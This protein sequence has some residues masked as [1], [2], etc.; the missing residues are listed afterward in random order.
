MSEKLYLAKQAS[1]SAVKEYKRLMKEALE[2]ALR[3]HGLSGKK[4][5]ITKQKWLALASHKNVYARHKGAVI[6]SSLEKYTGYLT[7]STDG[8]TASFPALYCF[9]PIDTVHCEEYDR[10]AFEGTMNIR[11]ND[12][13]MLKDINGFVREWILPYFT[14]AD[15]KGDNV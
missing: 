11:V 4:V 15:E 3:S 6:A 14:L 5:C 10:P 8:S 9:K 12:D 1:A 2:T 13:D 7:T